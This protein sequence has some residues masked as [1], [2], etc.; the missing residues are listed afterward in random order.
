MK[1]IL[2]TLGVVAGVAFFGFQFVSPLL[3]QRKLKRIASL[4]TDE[5]K[6]LFGDRKNRIFFGVAAKSLQERSEDLS[7]AF[8]AFLDMTLSGNIS[9]VILGKGCLKTY[10]PDVVKD[11]DLEKALLP[12]ESKARLQELKQKVNE[13]TNA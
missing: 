9:L 12:K 3:M 7:F 5:L 2:T 10:F 1:E 11:I 4:P 13:L 6:A 8:P